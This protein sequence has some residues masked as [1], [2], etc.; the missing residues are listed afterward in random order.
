MKLKIFVFPAIL[1]VF[2]VAL[3]FVSR[4][5]AA[6]SWAYRYT[7][8]NAGLKGPTVGNLF[9]DHS[10]ASDITVP[11]A[12]PADNNEVDLAASLDCSVQ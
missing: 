4:V 12:V 2:V 11:V 5:D 7:F 6:D 8:S 10:P 1:L 9:I 3:S